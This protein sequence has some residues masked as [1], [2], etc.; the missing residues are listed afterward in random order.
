[1]KLDDNYYLTTLDILESEEKLMNYIGTLFEKD[2]KQGIPSW[3][4]DF[5]F[6]DDNEQNM[7]IK[8]NNEIICDAKEKI[9]NAKNSLEINNRYKSILYTNGDEL[10]EVVFDILEHLFDVD[11]SDF[12]DE[13][14]EDFQIHKGNNTFIGEIKGVTSNIRN[15]HVSQLDVHF[16]SYIDEI[17]EKGIQ[18]SVYQLLIVNP[19]RSKNVTER[20]LVSEKQINLA[21]RN[22]CLI[23]ETLTLLRV[24][25]KY[26]NGLLDTS[27]WIEVVTNKN[28]LLNIKDFD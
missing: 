25:E 13:K 11:L 10:V 21:I 18:E 22:G 14:R 5:N 1:M 26:K 2:T 4:S 15:E 3:F 28:G 9:R 24:F 23:I 8:E 19:L 20:E 17:E 27:K 16:N 6:F 7:I 12:V